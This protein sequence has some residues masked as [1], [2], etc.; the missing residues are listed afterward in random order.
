M[1][2]TLGGERAGERSRLGEAYPGVRSLD[3]MVMVGGTIESSRPV[4]CGI[5]NPALIPIIPFG[6]EDESLGVCR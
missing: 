5:E 4:R 2:E 6:N 1:A 3:V